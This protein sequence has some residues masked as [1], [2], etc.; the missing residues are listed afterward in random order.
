M[1]VIDIFAAEVFLWVLGNG[2]L[3]IGTMQ[4]ELFLILKTVV[5]EVKNAKSYF[6]PMEIEI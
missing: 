4:S 1:K 2:Y 3:E 6:C 5:H